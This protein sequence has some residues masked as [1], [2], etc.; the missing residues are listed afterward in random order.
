MSNIDKKIQELKNAK[1]SASNEI[2]ELN[3]R[4]RVKEAERRMLD[5]FI[6]VLNELKKGE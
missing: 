2:V 4:L 3:T 5:E 6:D 1:Q